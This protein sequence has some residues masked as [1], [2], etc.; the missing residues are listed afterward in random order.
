MKTT[1]FDQ[2]DAQGKPV[3]YSDEQKALHLLMRTKG[4]SKSLSA[5]YIKTLQAEEVSTLARL[6]DA[7][8]LRGDEVNAV[9]DEIEDRQSAEEALKKQQESAEVA[10]E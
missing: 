1:A 10:A 7:P 9:I 2:K 8:S 4:W 6:E 3:I 5:G